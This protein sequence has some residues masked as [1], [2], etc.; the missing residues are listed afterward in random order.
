MIASFVVGGVH[1]PP[2]WGAWSP[3]LQW[4]EIRWLE[5]RWLE[6]T[7]SQSVG[8]VATSAITHKNQSFKYNTLLI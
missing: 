8:F 3:P 4:G 7:H 5:W 6:G 1:S 2:R